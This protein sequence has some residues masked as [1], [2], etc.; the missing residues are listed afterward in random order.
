MRTRTIIIL[1]GITALAIAGAM[2]VSTRPASTSNNPAATNGTAPTSD[3]NLFLP[4]IAPAADRIDRIEIESAGQRT[5]LVKRDEAWIVDNRAGYPAVMDRIAGLV[6]GLGSAATIEPRTS[7]PDLYDRIGVGEPGPDQPVATRVRIA[8]ADT[9]LADVILGAAGPAT[10]DPTLP[11]MRYARRSGED[12]AYLIATTAAPQADPMAWLNR[13]ALEIRPERIAR[14]RIETP[15]GAAIRVSR[16]TP[17]DT[18]ALAGLAEGEAPDAGAVARAGNA[19]GFISADN[20]QPAA[21]L[22]WSNARS[23]TFA[24]FDGLVISFELAEHEG[25]TW[26]KLAAAVDPA[27]LTEPE[28]AT[29]QP[30][31]DDARTP[32]P[33]Q[34]TRAN[35]PL[36]ISAPPAVEPSDVVP[37]T[38][39]M[40]QDPAPTEAN[41]P[42]PIELAATRDEAARLNAQWQ[43]WAYA[44]AEFKARQLALSRS[45]Y[46]AK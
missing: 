9:P 16:D 21:D 25:V 13:I 41:T 45:E 43:G 31:T 37:P 5:V 6:A 11:P 19:L 39:R 35:E 23:A 4:A 17:A 36:D 30:A 18:F 10:S 3:S 7:Q 2:V 20:I 14:V 15:D 29:P 33:D 32:I 26:A 1:T 8:A 34:T 44:L 22:D 38:D 42:E 27:A 12:R 28:P 40:T 46:L 24:T